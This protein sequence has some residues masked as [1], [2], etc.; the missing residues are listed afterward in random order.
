MAKKETMNTV[1]YYSM[2]PDEIVEMFPI[3]YSGE[4]FADQPTKM[5][6]G[7]PGVGKSQ[8]VKQFGERLEQITGKTVEVHVVSLLLM[9]PIDLRG[10]PSKS[11]K[12]I[13]LNDEKTTVDVAKWLPPDIFQ[14]NPSKNHINILFL[15]EISAAPPSVQAAAYQIALDKRVGEF[16]LPKNCV[17]ICAGNRTTDKA[18]AYTMPKPLA[19]RMTHIEIVS[20]IDS[21]RVWAFQNE[22]D[23]LVISF[24]LKNPGNLNTFSTNN[25]DVAFAT[26]R[27]WEM[28]NSYI[29]LAKNRGIIDDISDLRGNDYSQNKQ[30]FTLFKM[31]AGSVG[32]GIANE[33]RAFLSVHKYLPE[34]K[35]IANEKVKEVDK[36]ILDRI[37]V[38]Y[39]L[40]SMVTA[41]VIR[42]AKE[43]PDEKLVERTTQLKVDKFLTIIGK[44]IETIPNAEMKA[45]IVQDI[46][47]S[48][49]KP[50][51]SIINK[52]KGF[53]SSFAAVAKFL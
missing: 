5:L 52:N 40:C 23:P 39:A 11:Q 32:M 10:I 8:A 13:Y 48:V 37:D 47:A 26:P 53:N 28:V 3:M 20:N 15:D 43:I 44:Y 14:M 46:Y 1:N 51:G 50:F 30:L 7:P 33:F 41:G 24:I 36:K 6:W 17:V 29:K 27:S 49:S 12:E 42:F 22:V 4:D 34:F 45:K 18:V 21:W 2:T 9:S 35:D 16:K 19:N 31:I 25:D 38:L